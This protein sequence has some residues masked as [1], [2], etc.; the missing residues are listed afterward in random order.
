M[1]SATAA[2]VAMPSL[3]LMQEA[4]AAALQDRDAKRHGGFGRDA[5]APPDAG[6]GV[7][8]A[9][10]PGCQAPRR[11]RAGRV[12]ATAAVTAG[13]RGSRPGPPGRIGP[14]PGRGSRPEACRCPAR[15]TIAGWDRAVPARGCGFGVTH[16]NLFMTGFCQLSL[17]AWR[18]TGS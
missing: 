18:S 2:S 14:A 3:L 1:P 17:R 5:L 16:E 6:G 10:G 13:R 15:D 12:A 7:G 9:A 8:R 11:G 4:G